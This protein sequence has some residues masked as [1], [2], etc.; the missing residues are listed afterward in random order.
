MKVLMTADAVGGVWT[1]AL[2]LA[3]GLAPHGVQVTLATMGAWP[4]AA[5]QADA[6]A[7]PGLALEPSAYALEWMAQPWDDVAAA[8]E[9]L[10][11]LEARVQPDLVHLN[12]YA[13]GSLSWQAPLLIGGHSCVLSWW[14]AVHGEPAPSSWDRYRDEVTR[15]LQAADAVIAPTRSMLH[16]LEQHYGPLQRGSVI[17][18][19]RDPASLAPAQKEP[20]VLTA[21]RLWDAGK[22]LAALDAVASRLPWPVL[23][24]G[25]GVPDRVAAG[26]STNVPAAGSAEI[27]EG[28]RFG[29]GSRPPEPAA[30]QSP[31]Q[32]AA[33]DAGRKFRVLRRR[34]ARMIDSGRVLEAESGERAFVDAATPA[35]VR[36][37]GKLAPDA[38]AGWLARAAVYAL[39]AR[40]EPFGLS[41]LE[42]ALAGCAL[43]LGDIPSLREVWGDAAAFVPPDDYDALGRTLRA[44]MLNE[45]R[46]V[47]LGARARDRA[48]RYTVDRMA[49]Q[50][51]AA[52]RSLLDRSEQAHPRGWVQTPVA[53]SE[54]AARADSPAFGVRRSVSEEGV[55]HARETAHAEFR[56]E[57]ELTLPAR[58]GRELATSGI[59]AARSSEAA[60]AG[61][62]RQ[63]NP[64]NAHLA[65]EPDGE[66]P[67]A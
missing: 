48:R 6:A 30:G 51:A 20:F 38:L 50:Y 13:H 27:G 46:R 32:P 24:A 60:G 16:A 29:P 10:L 44:L 31:H 1:Y 2:E 54:R 65:P 56:A 34:D 23:A 36:W 58:E 19:G 5:Q 61:K 12:G 62:G 21:G 28:R 52:Y 22:N 66:G 57:S 39:P 53:A 35:G 47:E 3:R 4:T 37:L 40:Y 18:N 59:A 9:W 42:A 67:R 49:A 55:F 45:D 15:G 41:A 8:G 63:R 26:A 14:Q 64:A 17:A 43:V 33:R 7:V 25:D 11:A